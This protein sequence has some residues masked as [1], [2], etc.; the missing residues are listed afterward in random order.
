MGLLPKNQR[1]QAM[2]LVTVISLALVGVDYQYVWSPK[3]NTLTMLG[4][5]VDTLETRNNSARREM[6]TGSMDAHFL[7]FLLI[8]AAI[9]IVAMVALMAYHWA[10]ARSG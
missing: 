6:A 3:S 9:V 2:M 4:E 1:D 10:F 7:V 8:I 5:R